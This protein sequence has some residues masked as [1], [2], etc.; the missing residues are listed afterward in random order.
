MEKIFKKSQNNLLKQ[1]EMNCGKT[2]KIFGI[3]RK[4]GVVKK[5]I[6]GELGNN[7]LFTYKSMAIVRAVDDLSDLAYEASIRILKENNINSDENVNF[8]AECVNYHRNSIKNIF[9]KL[10]ETSKSNFK[11][12]IKS[13]IDDIDVKDISDYEYGVKKEIEFALSDNQKRGD[14]EFYQSFW[15]VN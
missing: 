9:S 6:D 12:N 8:V 10:N 2:P 15:R 13:F 14:I 7:L 4:D 11:Y 5:Y 3:L 1:Q